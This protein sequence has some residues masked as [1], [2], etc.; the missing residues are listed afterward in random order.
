MPSNSTILG[1]ALRN[2]KLRPKT[3]STPTSPKQGNKDS[4]KKPI[5]ATPPTKHDAHKHDTPRTSVRRKYPLN[6]RS[7]LV[8]SQ[9]FVV[10]D[11]Y[12]PI[13]CVGQGTYGIVCSALDKTTNQKVAIKRCGEVFRNTLHAKRMIREVNLLRNLRHR[14]VVTLLDLTIPPHD[15]LPETFN[16]I[17]MVLELLDHD[18]SRVIED[19][20]RKLEDTPRLIYQLLCGLAYM[21]SAEVAHRD[22]KPNNI[23][24]DQTRQT[25]CITDFGLCRALDNHEQSTLT[26]YVVTRCYRAP[27]LLCCNTIYDSKVDVWSAGC[28]AAELLLGSALFQG[29]DSLKQLEC[30]F[31]ILGTPT[32]E[33]LEPL[34]DPKAISWIR[35]HCKIP[36]TPLSNHFPP[37]IDPLA[38]DLLARML[39]FSPRNRISAAD[40]LLHPYLAQARRE[41]LAL[42]PHCEK[43]ASNRLSIE[44]DTRPEITIPELRKHL[45]QELRW[46]HPDLATPWGE[47]WESPIVSPSTSSRDLIGDLD[48]SPSPKNKQLDFQQH[49]KHTSGTP[50]P[51]PARNPLQ[52]DR[53]KPPFAISSASSTSTSTTTTV[54]PRNGRFPRTPTRALRQHSASSVLRSTSTGSLAL[55]ASAPGSAP[56]SVPNSPRSRRIFNSV[57][58]MIGRAI[59][60]TASSAPSSRSNSRFGPLVVTDFPSMTALPEH[61]EDKPAITTPTVSTPKKSPNLVQ[62]LSPRKSPNLVQ[63]LSPRKSPNLVQQ[64]S[65]RL[66]QFS[67][68]DRLEQR[69]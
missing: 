56:G 43:K 61:E 19:P 29:K 59:F 18:L 49:D 31:E 11:K 12:K 46:F 51:S 34:T 65:L 68:R 53:N 58:K 6:T 54:S 63:Q 42:D 44:I 22:I 52:H 23:L 39:S 26:K 41:A 50:L 28:V 5:H 47:T 64:L 20:D 27:E 9:R 57:N 33:D 7:W 32:E 55:S 24:L 4:Q 37:S 8:G 3:P 62:Q 36:P 14:N 2:D 30:I 17:Y 1:E 35:K 38:I 15:E 40:A 67:F 16:E 60:F 45:W 48:A 25:L 69:Q 66:R 10:P 21:H 13:A